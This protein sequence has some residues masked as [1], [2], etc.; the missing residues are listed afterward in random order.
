MPLKDMK[1][2]WG[3]E[4]EGDMSDLYNLSD[5]LNSVIYNDE[6][7]FFSKLNSQTH[8]QKLF[9]LRTSRWDTAGSSEQVVQLATAEIGILRGCVNVLDTCGSF[10][11]GT[12]FEF[13]PNHEIIDRSRNINFTLRVV[14]AKADRADPKLFRNLLARAEATSAIGRSI[15]ELNL[16]PNWYE[17]YKSLEAVME[18]Y[19][20]EKKFFSTFRVWESRIRLLKRTANSFRHTSGLYQPINNPMDINEALKLMKEIILHQLSLSPAKGSTEQTFSNSAENITY[21]SGEVGIGRPIITPNPDLIAT[22]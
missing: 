4:I 22:E 18:L 10:E 11:I 7:C 1:S 16:S 8:P 21:N 20:N 19:A 17:I 15:V 2:K 12:V 3:V 14:P 9:V 13:G 5:K 6:D